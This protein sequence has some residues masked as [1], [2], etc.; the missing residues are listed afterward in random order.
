[1][2]R[3]HC[4]QC[5]DLVSYPSSLCFLEH[6]YSLKESHYLLYFTILSLQCPYITLDI[7]FLSVVP[8][9]EGNLVDDV[10][11]SVSG[12]HM[13]H[14]RMLAVGCWLF[15]DIK[16]PGV[17]LVCLIRILLSLISYFLQLLWVHKFSFKYF[18]YRL[19][20]FNYKQKILKYMCFQFLFILVYVSSSL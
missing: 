3:R 1:M 5:T 4:F 20:Y 13:L 10:L 14:F 9:L 15:L 2:T 17:S 16:C 7:V 12:F 6:P 8:S 18:Q 11:L 19:N